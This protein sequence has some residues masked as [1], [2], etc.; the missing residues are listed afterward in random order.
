MENIKRSVKILKE[1]QRVSEPLKFSNVEPLEVI[2]PYRPQIIQF[3]SIDDFNSY[4]S[5][6]QNEFNETTQKLNKKYKIPGYRL[7]SLKG[8]LKIIKD[9]QSKNPSGSSLEIP[10]EIP[11]EYINRMKSLEEKIKNQQQMINELQ[12][13]IVEIQNYLQ[14]L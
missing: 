3:E 5:K 4:Y 11:L 9:Y 14:G 12:K 7:T 6:H 1:K 13:Q 10:L 8:K 2:E